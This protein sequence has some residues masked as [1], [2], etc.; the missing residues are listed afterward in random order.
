MLIKN[1]N[2]NI[3]GTGGWRVE[4]KAE[5]FSPTSSP[6]KGGGGQ[7]LHPPPPPGYWMVPPPQPIKVN[8]YPKPCQI[9]ADVPVN[10]RRWSNVGLML[11]HRLRRWSNIKPTLLQRLVFAGVADTILQAT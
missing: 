1:E 8:I 10:T 7:K 4:K 11:A 5:Q 9:N 6:I 3:C 2:P